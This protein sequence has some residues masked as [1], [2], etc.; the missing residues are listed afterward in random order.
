LTH[1]L[2]RLGLLALALTAPLAPDAAQAQAAQAQSTHRY[3][4]SLLGGVGGS[5]DADFTNPTF[6]LGWS[7]ATE[8]DTEFGIRLGRIGYGSKDQVGDLLGPELTYLSLAG[9]YRFQESFYSSGMFL[10]IGYYDIQGDHITDAGDSDDGFGLHFGVNGDFD[11]NHRWS[12][13]VELGAHWADLG[14]EKF[15]AT[16]LAGF[17]VKF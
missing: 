8:R 15:F 3:A 9:E 7:L 6:Q 13:I 10:G 14:A 16:G 11:I 5:S 17:A 12:V 4:L 1:R 2:L